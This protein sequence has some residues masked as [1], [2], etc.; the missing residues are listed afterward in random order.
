MHQR[1]GNFPGVT[2]ERKSGMLNLPNG[3]KATIT[4]LPGTY[5][6]YPT[7]EEERIACDAVRHR[8]HADYPDLL[9]IVVDATQLKR[10][11]V[12]VSQV[13]DLGIPTIVALNMT[14]LLEQ[15]DIVIDAE[16]LAQRLQTKVI[17]LSSLTGKGIKE[18]VAAIEQPCSASQ[19]RFFTPP[20]DLHR[21][22]D[23]LQQWLDT[24]NPYRAFQAL[25]YPNEFAQLSSEQV[26]QLRQQISPEQATLHTADE[27]L[28]RYDRIEAI[29]Q[30]VIGNTPTVSEKLT[31][32]L[33][34][35]L[36]HRFAG[37]A[38]FG[39]ILL[40]VFQSIFTWASYPADLIESA[41]GSLTAWL[42]QTLPTHWLSDLIVNGIVAGLG[43]IVIFIP[44][45]AFL[46]FFIAILE[47]SGYMSRV[48]FLLDRI[49]R[50]FGFSGRAIVP[51]IGG[52]ACA[53]PSIMMARSIPNPKERLIA[54]MVTPLMSCSARVPIYV[55]L[56]SM[57]VP[58][59]PLFGFFTLQGIAMTAMYILG[60]LTA[61]LA[62][63][64]LKKLLRY[65]TSGIY[66][67]EMPIYRMPRWKNVALM[68]Y[69]KCSSFVLEAGKVIMV[70]SVLLWF[71]ASHAPGDR[72]VQI[73]AQYD[74][75]LQL[76]NADT[77]T[78]ETARSSEKLQYSYAGIFGHAIEPVIRPLGFD[79]KIGISLLTSFA[80]REV[81]VGTM[82]TIYSVSGWD[83]EN[84]APIIDRMRA[85]INPTTGKP[86]Y[87]PAVGFALLVFY[88]FAMQCMSTLAVTRRET[89]SWKW[90]ILMLVYMTALAY[91]SAYI[92]YKVLS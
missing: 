54:I 5:S 61:L 62:A 43:G 76:P 48:M 9:V 81:F 74:A 35:I 59:T 16:L 68:I 44:Q 30:G 71:F 32:R 52:M 75:A 7:G 34:H 33:D 60:F 40:L 53:V 82:A 24:D 77:T 28:L 11:M 39:F 49:M 89:G 80:A 72:F 2:V 65:D 23:K 58:N 50:P 51:L 66:I 1:I 6:L 4:D 17:A 22:V 56:I 36:L 78:L 19:L 38:I 37:Y 15:D 26:R 57:F 20:L 47:E 21:S 70:I 45:I 25:L 41:F 13:V 88:A 85:E 69:Q 84:P 73:D 8:T 3:T 63:A 27:M 90:A 83:E 12:L 86:V 55:L 64:V 92:V 79:W 14:D 29:L 91:I 31:N 10:G 42:Q 87:T 67:A 18:L 46:F